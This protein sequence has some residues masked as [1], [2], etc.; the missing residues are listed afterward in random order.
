MDAPQTSG[1][2]V[3]QIISLHISWFFITFATDLKMYIMKQ[4]L[5]VVLLASLVVV[6]AACGGKKKSEDI[7]APRIVKVQP[8]EAFTYPD[9]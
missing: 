4:I 5:S 3:F 7:I 6:L 1:A 2:S 9:I 8:K